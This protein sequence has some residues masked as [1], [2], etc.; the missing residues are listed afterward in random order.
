MSDTIP[1]P[2]ILDSRIPNGPQRL[3]VWCPRAGEHTFRQVIP[4]YPK[5]AAKPCA[6]AWCYERK[7]DMLHM[8]PSLKVSTTCVDE[9]TKQRVE[10]ELFHNE[11]SW[12]V[13]VLDLPEDYAAA[14]IK[15]LTEAGEEETPH[16]DFRY[17]ALT[18]FSDEHPPEVKP[19]K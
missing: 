12:S 2:A 1:S 11:Y 9:A 19:S 15:E 3:A 10:H 6:I 7:G 18:R 17:R 8:T 16:W 5:G 14:V 4:V 13:K